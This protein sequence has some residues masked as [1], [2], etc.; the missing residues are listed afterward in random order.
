[1]PISEENF[2]QELYATKAQTF[3]SD[4]GI[5]SVPTIVKINSKVDNAVKSMDG[6]DPDKK[7]GEERDGAKD[8]DGKNKISYGFCSECGK[9][10]EKPTKDNLCSMKCQLAH[11]TK[12]ITEDIKSAQDKAENVK[13]KMG[14]ISNSLNSLMSTLSELTS[15]ITEV[16]NAGLDPKYTEYFK[17]KINTVIQY[18]KVNIEKAMISKNQKNLDQ[19]NKA[20]SGIDTS[21]VSLPPLN[22]I[23]KAIEA[24]QKLLE[25]FQKLYDQIYKMVCSVKPLCL[26]PESMSF[27]MT[28]RSAIKLPGKMVNKLENYNVNNS[29]GNVLFTDNI[30]NTIKSIFPPITETEYLMP[31]AAFNVRKALS[32]ENVEAIM[33]MIDVLK[34]I[35][36]GPTEPMPKY[37]ELKISNIHFLLF[38]L[39]SWGP[40]GLN[41]HAMPLYPP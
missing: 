33:K 14:N 1:M 37:E 11:N 38:L 5:T 10:L 17:V 9:P 31:P 32:Q 12:Y 35:M 26:E 25:Q 2:I 15:L 22:G 34:F 7:S 13:E 36:K 3:G 24:A 8:E 6:L 27:M 40:Q 4:S 23:Q 39:L 19:L 20:K 41:H 28:P 18:T 29:I 30:L 21:A 16:E